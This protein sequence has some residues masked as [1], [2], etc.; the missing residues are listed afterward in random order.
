MNFIVDVKDISYGTVEVEADSVE[1][2]VNSIQND[3]L[4]AE[5]AELEAFI[6]GAEMARVRGATSGRRQRALRD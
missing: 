6:Q 2:A 1:Q 3:A 4:R 5:L